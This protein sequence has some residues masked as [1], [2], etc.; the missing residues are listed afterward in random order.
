MIYLVEDKGE[1][2]ICSKDV[3][4]G[5][6]VSRMNS[7]VPVNGLTFQERQDRDMAA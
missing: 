3:R 1:S 5:R 2:S 7:L 4:S 6:Y